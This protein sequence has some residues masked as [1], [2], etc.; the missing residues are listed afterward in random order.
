MNDLRTWPDSIPTAGN[1][2]AWLPTGTRV[3][4][5]LRSLQVQGQ[6]LYVADYLMLQ[7]QRKLLVDALQVGGLPRRTPV[8][9]GSF[10]G[11]RHS[12]REHRPRRLLALLHLILERRGWNFKVMLFGLL[13]EM[14]NLE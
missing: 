13:L 14:I 7:P 6:G 11:L 1:G 2:G 12:E 4:L 3:G 5:V 9:A 10:Q 8:L